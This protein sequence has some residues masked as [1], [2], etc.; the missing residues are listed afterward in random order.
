VPH[1]NRQCRQTGC[2]AIVQSPAH[3]CEAH[4]CANSVTRFKREYDLSRQHLSH[5]R[6]YNSLR[7]KQL[8]MMKL[9]ENPFCEMEDVCVRRTGHP[10]P[11]T[12]V[13]HIEGVVEH[14]ELVYTWEN[15]QAACHEC[16]SAHTA[17]TEGWAKAK[18]QPI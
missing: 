16:H 11:S 4:T 18:T 13:H 10:A 1:T 15:L 6:I 17:R 5:R 8:R 2:A 3:Y 14:P 9:R 12:D 7:W